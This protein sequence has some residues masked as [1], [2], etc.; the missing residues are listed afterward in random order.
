MTGILS[1]GFLL[2]FAAR[3][4]AA[5]L[6]IKKVVLFSNGVGYFERQG[7]VRDQARVDLS[8]KHSEIDDILKSLLVLDLGNGRIGAVTY[9]SS[10]PGAVR[11]DEI[12]F[13][14]GG[15][16]DESLGAVLGQ[17]QGVRVTA[18]TGSGRVTGSVLTVGSAL[19]TA[20]DDSPQANSLEKN[21]VLVLLSDE[22][23]MFRVPLSDVRS[24]QILDEQSRSVLARF[25]DAKLDQRR[26]EAKKLAI[27]SD[28]QGERSLLVGYSLPA[29]IWKTTYRVVMREGK[30]AFFQG[31]AIVDN[32][33]D[34]DWTDVALSLVSGT[35]ISF[36][37]PLQQP[38]FMHRPVVPIPNNLRLYPQR[39]EPEGGSGSGSGSGYG[40]GGTGIA[41]GIPGGVVGGVPGGVVGGVLGGVPRAT[42]P[43]ATSMSD[44]IA[45]QQSGITQKA[46]GKEIG[47]LFEY[48]IDQPISIRKNSSALIPILQTDMEAERISIFRLGEDNDRPRTG[49]LLVNNSPVTL[50]SGAL[51]VLDNDTYAGEALIERLKPEERRFISFGVDLGT[52]VN[53]TADERRDPVF[54]VRVKAGALQ[55]HYYR[56]RG[57][58]YEIKNQTAKARVLYIEHPRE[59]GW[60]LKET[61]LPA[62]TT[63]NH[64]RFRV[65]LGPQTSSK[66]TV[67]DRQTLMDT[68]QLAGFGAVEMSLF[69]AQHRVDEALKGKLTSLLQAKQRISDVESRLKRIDADMGEISNDQRRLRDNIKA[70]E[71]TREAKQLIARYVAKVNDQEDELESLRKQKAD[72][73]VERQSRQQE[74]EQ[75][76]DAIDVS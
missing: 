60:T 63:A 2:T 36:I 9:D 23:T 34:E 4:S 26:R 48:K 19:R 44:L 28:G 21:P 71:G 75:A 13:A 52:L 56:A 1:L 67:T 59:T 42:T 61:Q 70:L 62:E 45:Q 14:V 12:P 38:L 54:L 41:R 7:M 64:Y 55:A 18:T 16:E 53:S 43:F 37:Q 20:P 27:V 17:M 39:Y 47:D 10:T 11:L 25:L 33:S 15:V 57:R 51:T 3:A 46:T 8:F 65:E 30:P 35:P 24:L 69:L 29:P 58:T 31:W 76:I 73:E 5:D 6:P 72:L 68:I 66:L 49:L 74:L 40:P 32:V 50:E 22:G